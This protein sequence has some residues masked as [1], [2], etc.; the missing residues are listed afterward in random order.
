M[1]SLFHSGIS[2]PGPI[3]VD[4]STNKLYWAD[5]DSQVIESSDPTGGNRQLLYSGKQG[6]TL[7][8]VNGIAVFGNFLYWVDRDEKLI[9]RINKNSGGQITIV[10]GRVPNLSDIH[11]AIYIQPEVVKA[12][13]CA[14]NNGNCSHICI[15]KTDHHAQCTCP[16]NLV[17]RKDERTCAE[18]STCPPDEF[19]CLTGQK[20]CIP[21][22]W[23]C[24]GTPE[25]TDKSDELDCPICDS[26]REFQCED[27]KCIKTEQVCDGKKQ[28]SDGGDEQACCDNPQQKKCLKDDKCFDKSSQCDGVKDCDD[29][30]D[31]VGCNVPQVKEST[32]QSLSAHVTVAIVVGVFAIAVLF[33]IVFA[34]RRKSTDTQFDDHDMMS[35][36]RPLYPS[37]TSTTSETQKNNTGSGRGKKHD[38]IKATITTTSVPVASDSTT[39]Y[40]RTKLT[41]ASSSSS[42]VTQYPKETL[43]PPP[44]PVTDRSICA[45]EFVDCTSNSPSTNRSH[46]RR[47]RHHT[48]PPPTTPCST[49]VCEESEPYFATRNYN[50]YMAEL[51]YDSDPFPPPPTPRSHYFSDEMMSGPDS[52]RT[53][54]S[55]FNPLPPPPSPVANSDC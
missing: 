20:E 1:I 21:Y 46:K 52:P 29:G 40:D 48:R 6:A 14:R 44:S 27:K 17:L 32:A 5:L 13:P 42:A 7:K 51:N 3:T 54:R 24:D 19:T 10:Q 16:N 26:L 39:A 50:N 53:E 37:E 18:K 47:R 4:P 55:Y 28:C 9:G 23:K 15:A 34:C 33:A 49:D 43:N 8:T 12:H 41:G 35:L 38:R 22:D 11:A 45:G 25:C 2:K 31:E 30:S 36:T